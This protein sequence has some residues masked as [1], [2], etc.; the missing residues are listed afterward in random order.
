MI[1]RTLYHKLK[2]AAS[3]YPVVSLTGPRQSGKTTLAKHAFEN[4][5]Y[6]S[7]EDPDQRDFA[8]EDPRGF[9]SR[10]TKSVI[11]DEIQRVP[12][13]F[14]YI[15]T[16]VDTK[17][18]AGQ[19]IL[20]GSRNFLLLQS[21]SQTLAGRCAILHLM[22]FS[23]SELEGRKPFPI[24]D[25]GFGLPERMDPTLKNLADVLVTGFYPRIHDKGLNAADW[26]GNYYQ[27]YI[28]RDVRDIVNIGDLEIFGRFVRLCAGRNGQLL[29]LSS[30][31]NDC[32]ITHTTAKRWISI[33]ETSFIIKL[34][35]PHFRNF[36][37]RLIKSPKLYFLDTGLL[38]YLLR[39]RTAEELRIHAQ[40]GNIFESYAI[41]ELVKNYLNRGEE[42]PLY[43]WRDSSGNEIDIII[44]RGEKMI[45]LEIKAGQTV[46]A[47]YFKG[48]RYWKKLL[49]NPQYPS[50]VLYGGS[51][52]YFRSDTFVYAWCIL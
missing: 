39:I 36:S 13:L 23:L 16:I 4:F 19:F 6:I 18:T 11:L 1:D 27:T 34:L 45:P 28:E 22:P 33:L 17:G 25:M 41:S 40:L 37:K 42:P 20:T 14:S 38:C 12:E 26:L 51:T 32:G 30:L 2:T 46:S 9:L 44:D 29:N 5:T 10:F 43:F 49:D 15:Q 7:L 50:A 8:I 52:S 35:R 24:D 21:V 47:D 31:A 48:I 3:Q